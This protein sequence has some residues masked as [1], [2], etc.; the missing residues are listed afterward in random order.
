[1]RLWEWIRSWF[2][3]P[4]Q[5]VSPEELCPIEDPWGERYDGQT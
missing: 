2:K 3:K 4:E 1:M 5:P